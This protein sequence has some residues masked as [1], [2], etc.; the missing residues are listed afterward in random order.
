MAPSF[1]TWPTKKTAAPQRFAACINSWAE[2][3]T[4]LTVPGAESSVGKYMVW[5]ESITT[6]SKPSPSVRLAAISAAFVAVANCKGAEDSCRR[7]ARIR[8]C[9]AD[10]SP[11]K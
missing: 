3:R 11:E 9:S 10:S 4:W 5:M 2:A 1:V 8:T 6:I 7:C